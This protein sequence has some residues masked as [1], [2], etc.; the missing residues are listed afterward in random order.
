MFYQNKIKYAS[1]LGSP[2]T[3]G[4][5]RR[6]W[7]LVRYTHTSS[8]I[9]QPSCRPNEPC[10]SSSFDG[11]Y[12]IRTARRRGDFF[13][14][15]RSCDPW[16]HGQLTHATRL[17]GF[18]GWPWI[19]VFD[20]AKTSKKGSYRI[21]AVYRLEAWQLSPRTC[22]TRG[23]KNIFLVGSSCLALDFIVSF[24][25]FNF[26]SLEGLKKCFPS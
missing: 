20:N 6:R 19:V 23:L 24:L 1:F 7:F 5:C 18:F 13:P 14:A 11:L 4:A 12:E 16:E 3:G 8:I 9:R 10:G 22:M 26:V 2:S 15:A 17:D 25:Y 21:P